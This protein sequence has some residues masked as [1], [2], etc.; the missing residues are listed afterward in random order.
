MR[1]GPRVN[2]ADKQFAAE[3]RHNG[4]TWGLT[5]WADDWADAER[6]LR[7]I[8]TNGRVIGSDVHQVKLPNWLGRFL[9]WAGIVNDKP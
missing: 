6:K 7:S 8:G 3:Y 1:A 9:L 5:I 4:A 2:K